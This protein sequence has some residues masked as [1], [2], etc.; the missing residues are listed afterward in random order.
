MSSERNDPLLPAGSRF[1]RLAL[2]VRPRHRQTLGIARIGETV[3]Q[4]VEGAEAQ[5]E[6][7]LINLGRVDL[8][9]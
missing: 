7:V 2:L 8:A 4:L 9:P 3:I 5:R 6:V 1:E